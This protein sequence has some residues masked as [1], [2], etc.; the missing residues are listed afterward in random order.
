MKKILHIIHGLNRGGAETFIFNLIKNSDNRS[1]IHNIAIQNPVISHIELKNLCESLGG[2]IFIISD[3]RSK[4]FS[5]YQDLKEL[6]EEG[7][8]FVHIHNNALINPVPLIVASKYKNRVILHSHNTKNGGGG[9]LGKLLH[10]INTSFFIKKD[11]NR[12]ACG[13]DAGKWMYGNRDFKIVYNAVNLNDFKFNKENSDQ[14]RQR[15]NLNN[16]FIIGHVGRFL[17]VKNQLFLIKMFNELIKRDKT[18]EYALMLIGDGPQMKVAKNLVE[19]LGL[20]NKVIFTG[21]VPNPQVYYSAFDCFMLPSLYEGFAFVAVEA[22]ASGLKVIASNNNTD[23]INITGK[24]QFLPLKDMNNWID[25]IIGIKKDYNHVE[26]SN[27][28]VG[29][30]FDLNNFRNS[31][32]DIYFS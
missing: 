30:A 32:N 5:H 25:S 19:K 26:I 8:D 18:R 23:E 17:P 29:S 14:I 9:L 15:Y 10:K 22:Q 7:F 21:N 6:L 13:R 11:I 4:I 27:K 3:F 20:K 12:Y 2:K 28:L 16:N 24:V 1:L 31:V